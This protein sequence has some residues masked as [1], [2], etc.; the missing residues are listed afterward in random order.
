MRGGCSECEECKM[1]P[2]YIQGSSGKSNHLTRSEY[3]KVTGE[4]ESEREKKIAVNSATEIGNTKG[5]MC[6]FCFLK[7]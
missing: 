5:C 3:S 7:K 4:G 6:S 1:S 2:F